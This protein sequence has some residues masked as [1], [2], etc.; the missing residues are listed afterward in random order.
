MVKIHRNDGFRFNSALKHLAA[1]L[2]P[3]LLRQLTGNIL[4]VITLRVSRRRR[5]MYSGH[6]RLCVR[7]SVGM[8]VRLSLATCKHYCTDPDVTWGMVGGAL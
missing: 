7:L 4:N 1:W 3:Y 2:Y 8:S 5:E 6:A